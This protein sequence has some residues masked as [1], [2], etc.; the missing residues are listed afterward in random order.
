MWTYSVAHANID[1][2]A[3]GQTTTETFTI[4]IADQGSTGSI[5]QTVTVTVTGTNDAPT[6][7]TAVGG[8]LGELTEDG[9]TVADDPN[10]VGVEAG[11]FR[12]TRARL[13]STTS[14]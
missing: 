13:P 6:I 3:D 11:A 1:Y 12:W 8:N 4:T 9:P 2:L 10:T 7:T 5:T 14:T